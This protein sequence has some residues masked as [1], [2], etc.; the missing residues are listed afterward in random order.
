MNPSPNREVALFSAALEL[1]PSERAA[2]LDK[3]CADDP[4]LRQRLDELLRAHQDAITFLEHKAPGA[5]DSPMGTEGPGMTVRLPNSPAEKPGDRISRYK[6]L[7]Q[8]GEGGCGVVY[9]AEQEQPV[10]RRVALKVIKLGMDTKQVVARFEAERQALALMDHPN[11]AKVFDAGATG[12]GRPYF[13]MELVRGIKLT[14]YCDEHNLPTEERLKLFIQVCQAVQHA[15]QKGIIHRD[16]KPSNI[17]VTVSEPGGPGCPKVIDFGIAKAT[18]GQLLTDKTLF[19]AFEQFMGT[20]AY[21]SPEQAMMTA[22]DI[23]TRTDIYSLGVLLYELLTGKTPLD[24]K[25]LLAAGL[26]E[27]RRTIRE[28]EPLRPSTRLSTMLVGELTAA[29]KHRHTDPPRLIHLL[30]GDLDWIVMKALEKDRTRRYET[31]NGFAMDVQRYVAD[32]P[33]LARP[34]SAVYRFQKAFRRHKLVLTAAG[35]V[36]AALILGIIASSWQSVRATR[37][38]QAALLAEAQ[39]ATQRQLA[40]QESRRAR[41]AKTVADHETVLARHAAAQADARYLLQARLL[42]AA[43]TKATEAFNLGG[44][45]EDGLLIHNIAA[46][47]RNTWLLAARVPLSGP[48]TAACI[49]GINDESCVVLAGAGDV[50]VRDSRNG[51]RLGAVPFADQTRYLFQGPDTN[52]VVAISDSEASILALPSLTVTAAKPLPAPPTYATTGGKL[53]LLVLQNHDVCLLDLHSLSEIG[54]FNWDRN[55][56]AKDLPLPRHGCISPDGKLVLL[57]GGAWNIPVLFWDRHDTPPTFSTNQIPQQ[58]FQ[59]IDDTHLAVWHMSSSSTPDAFIALYDHEHAPV[60]TSSQPVPNDDTKGNLQL[61]AFSSKAWGYNDA[62]PILALVGPSGL[63]LK[64]VGG[65]E[66]IYGRTDFTI[67]DRYANLLPNESDALAFLAA[68]AARGILALRG[69]TNIL[70]FQL[71]PYWNS[72]VVDYCATACRD[73]LLCVTHHFTPTSVRLSFTPFDPRRTPA[74]FSLQWPSGSIWVPWAIAA[75]PDASTL[76]IVA[77]ESDSKN[78]Y[79]TARYSRIRALLYHPGELKSAPSAW[80][81]ASAFELDAPTCNG[82][83]SRFAAL[84]P[85]ATALLYWSS[86]TTVTRYDPRDGKALGTLELG[87]VS[88]RSRDG[89][90]VAAVSPAGRLRVYD[91]VSGD[92]LLDLVTH[93]ASALCFSTDGSRLVAAETNMLRTYDIASAREL[94][95]FQSPLLPLAYPSKGNRFLAFE[96]DVAGADGSLVLADTSDGRVV[97]V[98]NRAGSTFTPAFFSNSG[99]QLALV[100]GRWNAEVIRSLHPDELS[101][102]LTASL[103]ETMDVQSLTPTNIVTSPP[104]AAAILQADDVPVLLSRLGDKITIQGRVR[105]VALTF[106]RNAVN[107]NFVGLDSQQVEV[108]VPPQTFPKLVVALGEDLASVLNGRTIRA[109]GRLSKYKQSLEVTLDNTSDLAVVPPTTPSK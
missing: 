7:Q 76:A 44:E 51:A 57:H 18:T 29:A 102:V 66:P 35:A 36:A 23:D 38:K 92:R 45:W 50:Q 26:E 82:W 39:E 86:A 70:I 22:L 99:E 107:I 43:L 85:D 67:S 37:A 78:N 49:A 5:Q 63:V 40:E 32:E 52:T 62:Y 59:F 77:Q 55:P 80:P 3:A 87:L 73:G 19:T 34:P 53:L 16:I 90:R 100:Y 105:D 1:D 89:R 48:V 81:I 27:M 42:P 9:M 88:A 4:A 13:V 96:P 103:P 2:Y 31:A 28:K 17:L 98:L 56:A 46:A 101:S 97:S 72:Q 8:I 109:T 75:T 83:S 21:M 30:R 74:R 15:H 65:G 33:V 91:I 60:R 10:R 95:S 6:L 104:V 108:W 68:D 24:Q 20:P 25:E 14:D 64:S 54:S 84:A 61:Q 106:A 69:R 93:P 12:T 94:S 58:Q 79:I 71:G 41:D 47:A 11:I